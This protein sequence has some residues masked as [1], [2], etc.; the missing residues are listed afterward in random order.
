MNIE[1]NTN[2]SGQKWLRLTVEE[3]DGKT[4]NIVMVSG[5]NTP[6]FL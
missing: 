1:E 3:L 6:T 5:K 4:K 2:K